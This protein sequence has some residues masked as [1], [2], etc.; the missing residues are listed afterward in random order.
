MNTFARTSILKTGQYFL[1]LRQGF[2]RGVALLLLLVVVAGCKK[3]AE[4][5]AQAVPDSNQATVATHNQTPAFVA[6]A[7]QPA[8]AAV[9]NG[10]PDIEELNR[11]LLRWLMANRRPPKDFED[12]AATAGV[13]I[14]PPPAGK[15]YIIAKNMHIQLVNR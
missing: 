9:P 11:S 12:F 3:A 6:P 7:G 5:V 2:A 15:K 4:P 8:A 10:Q 13:P 1:Y 14:P